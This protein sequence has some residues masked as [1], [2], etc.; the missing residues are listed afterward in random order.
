MASSPIQTQQNNYGIKISAPNYNALTCQDYQLV[1][2]SSWPQLPILKTFSVT[3][4]LTNA[5]GY[6]T[7]ET[8]NLTHNAGF[9]PLWDV[10]E[11]FHMDT[12]GNY[13]A[14]EPIR[15]HNGPNSMFNFMN[16]IYMGNKDIRIESGAVDSSDPPKLE[17]FI[18]I[19]DLDIEKDF[20]Y[21]YLT[22]PEYKVAYTRDYGVKTV[23]PN[24]NI[25]SNDMRDFILHSRC[26]SP[27]V[28]A[29]YNQAS[30][31]SGI[32]EDVT[33]TTPTNSLVWVRGFS[34]FAHNS[35]TAPFDH[36]GEAFPGGQALG[37][38]LRINYPNQGQ[39]TQSVDN[40][41]ILNVSFV[42]FRDP[43]FY[44]N[45]VKVTYG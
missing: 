7:Y 8:I 32:S 36:Y 21:N 38:L 19:Y 16:T 29:V 13:N 23:L 1:F 37:E 39:Y 10:Y 2:N 27:Q 15:N 45:Q 34:K 12:F 9:F 25:N 26:Q 17:L 42:A 28:L 24:K 22:P 41:N 18:V 30:N 5:P 20:S 14:D 35:I 6:Y 44:P 40:N 33:Y 43:L 31:G 3:T 11:S 4:T